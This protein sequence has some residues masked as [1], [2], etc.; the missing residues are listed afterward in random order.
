VWLSHL[1]IPTEPEHLQFPQDESYTFAN[2]LSSRPQVLIPRCAALKPRARIDNSV[3]RKQHDP[4][5][6]RQLILA[7]AGASLTG[8]NL[9]TANSL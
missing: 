7:R 4:L 3:K 2:R 1:P 9:K 8:D 5:R 6:I